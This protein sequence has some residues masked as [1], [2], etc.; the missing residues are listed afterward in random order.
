MFSTAR[1]SIVGLV[2]AALAMT[3]AV[4][5]TAASG[6]AE[7]PTATEIGVTATEIHIAVIADVDNPI[8]PGLFQG[9]VDGVNGA[10]KYLNSKAGGRGVAGRKLVVD[11]TDSKL[12]AN[13]A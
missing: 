11:F 10:A 7:K 1:V 8:V 12:N 4:S 9:A 2:C 3:S 13:A 5:V 6:A